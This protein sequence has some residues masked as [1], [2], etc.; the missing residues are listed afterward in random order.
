MINLEFAGH[1]PEDIAEAKEWLKRAYVNA[2]AAKALVEQNDLELRVEVVTQVQQACEKAIKAILLANGKTYR[3]VT[4]MRHNAIG[5]YVELTADMLV[6][7][8]LAKDFSQALLKERTTESANSLAISVLR[9]RREKRRMKYVKYAFKQVLPPASN[10]LGNKAL[11]VKEWDRLTRAFPPQVVEIFID[12][13]ENISDIWRQRI[14]EVHNIYV[15]PRPLLAKEVTLE[16]W[17]FS[18]S[19]AGLTRQSPGQESDAQ[20]NQILMNL[21]QQLFNAIVE[22]MIRDVDRKDWPAEINFKAALLYVSNW[23]TSLGWL[24]LCAVITT[25][26]AVSS[27]YPAEVFQS[28]TVIG[29]QHYGDH[30]GVITCISPLAIHTEEAIRNLIGFYNQ[31]ENGFRQML[32]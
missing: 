20:T 17:M 19:Y 27:R 15:D 18:P 12:L 30:L 4:A 23:L 7:N 1:T 6:S 24:F 8:P 2:K 21:A 16:F 25:P 32:R 3:E 26:H 28:K 13:H 22:E 11:E 29:S 10:T 5:A 14:N 9:D 31:I